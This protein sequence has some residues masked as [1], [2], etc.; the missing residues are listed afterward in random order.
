MSEHEFYLPEVKIRLKLSEGV[1]L[2]SETP[3]NEPSSAVRVMKDI[4]QEM[5]IEVAMV[6]NLD[7]KLRPIN[8]SMVSLGDIDSA[9]M[10]ARNIFKS[11]L[12]SNARYMMLFHNHPSGDI[13]PSAADLKT[14]TKLIEIGKFMDIPILDHII[15]GAYK[16]EQYSF[17]QNHSE[18]FK[19]VVQEKV[20]KDLLDVV[21]KQ[22]QKKY[23][24]SPTF[25]EKVHQA[26][27][28][29][30]KGKMPK[31]VNKDIER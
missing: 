7:T 26:R 12:L 18:L 11:A 10:P 1:Q 28:T 16:G 31:K 6:V 14:T 20:I 30:T 8:F 22:E 25:K 27:K 4:L 19:G 2:Y 23:A 29:N 3:L 15:V 21:E 13:H 17:R 24:K 9:I 5:D